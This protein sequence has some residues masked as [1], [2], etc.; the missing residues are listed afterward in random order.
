MPGKDAPLLASKDSGCIGGI[1][2]RW[3]KRKLVQHAKRLD[4]PQ[5]GLLILSALKEGNLLAYLT[6]LE[7]SPKVAQLSLPFTVVSTPKQI[8]AASTDVNREEQ[9]NSV[10]LTIMGLRA[11]LK[12][13]KNPEI[14]QERMETAKQ[15]FTKLW[16]N[17][18]ARNYFTEKNMWENGDV[19]LAELAEKEIGSKLLEDLKKIEPFSSEK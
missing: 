3:R 15:I 16:K 12:N 18:H 19:T 17:E 2:Q 10:L 5:V 14:C 11:V 9:A 1:K 8:S 4:D 13:E 7:K 6:F